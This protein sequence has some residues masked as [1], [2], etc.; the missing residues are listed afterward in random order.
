MKR[1]LLIVSIFIGIIIYIALMHKERPG[2]PIEI[3]EIKEIQIGKDRI[4]L[5]ISEKL[6]PT[7][8]LEIDHIQT[9]ILQLFNPGSNTVDFLCLIYSF[10]K[11]GSADIS[12]VAF[13]FTPNDSE[14]MSQTWQGLL[15]KYLNDYILINRKMHQFTLESKA[16]T[17]L[18]YQVGVGKLENRAKEIIIITD[19]E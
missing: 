12:F 18:E 15:D 2:V 10:M 14:I 17:A 19:N 3:D 4:I 9:Y 5:S 1:I 6:E 16:K 11:G 13:V 7:N 8:A